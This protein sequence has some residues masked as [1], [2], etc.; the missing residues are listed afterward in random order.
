MYKASHHGSKN[1]DT[2][3]SVSTWSPE[4]VVISVGADNSYGHP[5]SEALALYESV[6]AEI[7]RT[8]Q[9]G[10]VSVLGEADG[11][12]SKAISIPVTPSSVVR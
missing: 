9:D 12:Y 10:T 2:Q 8:D 7:Y 1:G 5:T 11:S 4:M 3:Q 6:N